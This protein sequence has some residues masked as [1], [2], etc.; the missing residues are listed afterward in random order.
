MTIKVAKQTKSKAKKP[1]K[2]V[3]ALCALRVAFPQDKI[4]PG[5]ILSMLRSGEFYCSI[6]RYTERFGELK[7]VLYSAK[8]IS[9]ESAFTQVMHQFLDSSEVITT[10]RKAL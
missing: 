8:A 2:I 9:W 6:Q 10:L 7:I 1:E 5:I 3:A 4:S